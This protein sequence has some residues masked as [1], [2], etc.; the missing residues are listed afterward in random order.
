MIYLPAAKKTPAWLA[1]LLVAV[2]TFAVFLPSLKNGFV[3]WDDFDNLTGNLKF[4][5]LGW[6]QLKWMFTTFH[7]GPYQPLSWMSYGADYLVWGMD[8]FGYHLT[9]VLLHSFNAGLF[10]LLCQELFAAAAGPAAREK[11]PGLYLGAGF[12]ALFFAVHPLR[13]E[14]V[15]WVTERRDVLSGLFYLL[16]VLWYARPRAPGAARGSAWRRH[17]LPLAAFLLALLSKGIVITLPFALIL[18]DIF[19]LRRLPLDPKLWFSRENRPAWLEKIPYF[20]LAAVFGAAGYLGQA[21][22]GAVASYQ[23]FGFSHRAAQALFS[24][25]LYLCKTLVPLDLVPEYKFTGGLASWRPLLA[26]AAAL[27]VTSVCFA[28]RR[29]RPALLAAWLFFLVTLSPV[30]GILKLGSQSA[31]DRYTY[32][33]CLG[34]AL[35]AG[36]GMLAC[37]RGASRR[38]RNGCVLCAGLVLALLAGLAWR[39]QGFWR[40]SEILWRHALAVNPELSFAHYNL[41]VHVAA[42]G[43]LDEAA[44]HYR[45]AVRIIPRFSPGHYS[46]GRIAAAQGRFAESAE[47][48]RAALQ[49]NPD[50]A[51]AHYNFGLVLAAQ[52]KAAEA[53]AHYRA[54]L[55]VNPG[56]AEAQS[57]LGSLLA[58]A[59]RYGE[60]AERYRAALALNQGLAEAHYNLGVVLSAQGGYEAA[61]EQYRAA[62][63]LEPGRAQARN[64]LEIVLV[65]LGKTGARRQS[66]KK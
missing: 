62:L 21:Q 9:N 61:A 5:G 7:L 14:S 17:G 53:E 28:Q 8:P 22:A 1:P 52:G 19:A 55:R 43:R 46:L 32:L 23:T 54:A 59:G 40:D 50:Y 51:L 31:A 44:G 2:F 38:L 63:R 39:Q 10:C 3:N 57:S 24:A 34:F 13:V 4:R 33:P 12:A 18:L 58:R 29:L 6:Q 64:N 56:S 47:H 26:A 49:I 66:F 16:A 35:L 15:S 20:A 48:Y 36:A 25:G 42:Q 60:A 30:S 11:G 45:D 41:G 37:L 65:K 27:A